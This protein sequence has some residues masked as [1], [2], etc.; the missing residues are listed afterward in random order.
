MLSLEF[1]L[2]LIEGKQGDILPFA[3]EFQKMLC[4]FIWTFLH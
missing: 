3:K 1:V 4:R 2:R